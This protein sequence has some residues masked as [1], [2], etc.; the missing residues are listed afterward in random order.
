M[1]FGDA[2]AGMAEEY[3]D[4]VDGNSGEQ[5]LDGEGVAEHVAVGALGCAVRLAQIGEREE[6]AVAAL[7]VGD[8]GFGVSVAR[9]EK[10]A[11]IRLQ[12]IW[13]LPQQF[14]DFRRQRQR[15]EL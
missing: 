6:A 14:G 8:E 10:I 13:H 11:R 2:D 7:P 1:L 3:G 12:A 4:L 5:H 9:P 15:D